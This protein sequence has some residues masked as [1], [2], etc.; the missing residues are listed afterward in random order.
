[1]SSDKEYLVLD[2]ADSH[3]GRQLCKERSGV[4]VRVRGIDS[5]HLL[6]LGPGR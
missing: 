3:A 6:V 1:M 5:L 2:V 4:V